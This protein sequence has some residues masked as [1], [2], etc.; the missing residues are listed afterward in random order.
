MCKQFFKKNVEIKMF[1]IFFCIY[2]CEK[3]G[4]MDKF[5][6]RLMMT[7]LN[8]V[9]I[10]IFLIKRIKYFNGFAALYEEHDT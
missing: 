1:I 9:I 10:K 4:E 8:R 7:S 2:M 5:T 3:Q 6:W